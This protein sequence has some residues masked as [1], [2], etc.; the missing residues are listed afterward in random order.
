MVVSGLSGG[1]L[2]LK[3]T[4]RALY[5]SV[6]MKL[7]MKLKIELNLFLSVHNLQKILMLCGI[8][9]TKN[10]CFEPN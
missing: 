1:V 7:K 6:N 10:Y 3:E 8:T 5:F 4:D 2:W 9:C